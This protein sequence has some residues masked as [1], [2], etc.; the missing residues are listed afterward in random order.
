MYKKIRGRKYW[1]EEE[2]EG[3]VLLMLHGFTGS[4]LTFEEIIEQFNTTFRVV[5]ID[6]PGH[7]RTGAIGVL[8]MEQFCRDL[9]DLL[10]QMNVDKVSL[11]GYSMGGR[12]ALSF[13]ILYPELVDKLILES[14]S[15]GLQSSE[16]QLARQ[17]KDEGLAR[18]VAEEGIESFVTMWENI[19]LFRT[20]V[21][22]SAEAK[23]KL[24]EERT[25]QDPKGLSE[26][27]IGMGTGKQPS[28]WDRLGTVSADVLLITGAEDHKFHRINEHMTKELPNAK[29]VTIDNAGH[30]VHLEEPRIFAKIVEDFMI[31]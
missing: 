3:P 26:S 5:R 10:M 20:Q 19:P 18:K 1:V 14:A 27:L 25:K 29:W 4:T 15:P 22:L 6:L 21:N 2:G 16:D 24:R 31:Q 17:A 30:T 8:T 13:S 9:K 11:L 7:A 28:W 23:R 12:T